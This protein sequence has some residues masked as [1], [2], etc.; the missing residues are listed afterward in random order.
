MA[1]VLCIYQSTLHVTFSA[2]LH[3][4]NTANSTGHEGLEILLS[5]V[6]RIDWEDCAT[7]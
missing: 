7:G 5:T 3:F 4:R 1:L 2:D 6:E